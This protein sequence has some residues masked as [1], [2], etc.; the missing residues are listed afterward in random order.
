M[1]VENLKVSEQRLQ[2]DLWEL[3][4]AVTDV[5]VGLKK[6]ELE[7][8]MSRYLAK[9]VADSQTSEH[10]PESRLQNHASW[11]GRRADGQSSAPSSRRS[12]N[13]RL[14][15]EIELWRRRMQQMELDPR[16]QSPFG[17]DRKNSHS[18]N[19]Q[20]GSS[21]LSVAQ[22][23]YCE[24]SPDRALKKLVERRYKE[25]QDH[26][27]HQLQASGHS[28]D[29]PRD[30]SSEASSAFWKTVAPSN[31]NEFDPDPEASVDPLSVMDDV[32][33]W[34]MKRSLAGEE[35]SFMKEVPIGMPLSVRLSGVHHS[36]FFT[37]SEE[38]FDN[39]PS[40]AMRHQ[41][42]VLLERQ[43]AARL[44]EEEGSELFDTLSASEPEVSD[45]TSISL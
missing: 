17:R 15:D 23:R 24:A 28:S 9:A 41:A 29:A 6:P 18:K 1:E 43:R 7:A 8:E 2:T 34:L 42:D 14:H 40:G 11:A 35:C 16:K 21:E 13:G 12:S 44:I 31:S 38:L 39:S 3:K 20:T 32:D 25:L 36:S 30:W 4:Q 19:S 45:R 5:I 37:D 26:T 10:W 27:W 33:L 22:E